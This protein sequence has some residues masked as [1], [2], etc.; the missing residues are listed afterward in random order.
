MNTLGKALVI[1][2]TIA[3]LL[4]MIVAAAVY[5]THT[6]WKSAYEQKQ[7]TLND[8]TNAKSELEAKYLAQVSQ[9]EAEREAAQQEVRKLESEKVILAGENVRIQKDV[10]Q[11]NQDR[12]SIEQL[13]KSTEANNS[14]LTAEV[15]KLR[16][17]YRETQQF[18]DEAFAKTLEATSALHVTAGNLETAKNRNV[19]LV[20]QLAEK[21]SA[22]RDSGIDPNAKVVPHVRGKISATHLADGG[23]LIEITIGADDGVVPGQTIEVFRG[24]RYLGRAV[25]LK[26]DPDRAVARV[27]RKFQ[28]GQIQEDD[29]VATKLR[30]G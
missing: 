18:R 6:N 3:C 17:K 16:D 28:Q 20:S 29:D 13:V 10:D 1:A 26:A 21:T 15:V 11:L 12:R 30:V 9:L 23:Q 8:A 7:K 4:L 14:A 19:Q 27:L 5:S 24:E 22:L 25:I 2:I